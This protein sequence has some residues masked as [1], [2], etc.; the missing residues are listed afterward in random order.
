VALP[1]AI[2]DAHS[3]PP[4]FLED[5]IIA[6]PPLGV[7][8]IDFGEHL[9]QRF[10]GVGIGFQTA[11]EQ[12]IQTETAPDPRSRSTLRARSNVTGHSRGI[13]DAGHIH[14]GQEEEAAST[15]Q[16]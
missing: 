15:A 2:D 12:A 8:D 14:G 5:L 3:A 9:I 13:G 4:N 16:R 10:G 6:E 7:A 1:C 11:L